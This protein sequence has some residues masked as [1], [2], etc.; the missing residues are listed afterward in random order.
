MST[1]LSVW[2]NSVKRTVA[3]V[4]GE[5]ATRSELFAGKEGIWHSRCYQSTNSKGELIMAMDTT[6]KSSDLSGTGADTTRRTNN[7]DANPDPITGAPKSHPIGTGVGAAAGGVAA[8]LAGAKIGA[9]AGTAAMPGVGTAV[10][11][12]IG[13]VAGG[14]IGKGVA[15]GVNP[16]VENEYWK[17]NYSTRPYVTAGSKY[18]DYEPAYR[19]GWESRTKHSGRQFDEVESDLGRDWDSAK[20]KSQMTW[21]RAKDATRDAWDRLDNDPDRRS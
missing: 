9:V 13:A 11:A 3:D 6:R 17:N 5:I 21:D 12:A 20:G 7:P 2:R 19:Y 14:L 18:D 10:G 4:E 8:G 16:S 15:E 1:V